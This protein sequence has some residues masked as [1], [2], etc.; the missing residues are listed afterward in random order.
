MGRTRIYAVVVACLALVFGVVGAGIAWAP[1][2]IPPTLNDE[3]RT[4]PLDGSIRSVVVRTDLGEI[5][6]GSGSKHLIRVRETWNYSR[7]TVTHT[8]KNGVLTVQGECPNDPTSWNRCSTD[9]TVVVPSAVTVDAFSNFGDITTKALR[10]N[11][12]LASDF[13]ELRALGVSAAT[14]TADTDY[15][16]VVLDLV[17]APTKASAI[18][19]F[20]DISVKVPAGT[21][22]VDAKTDFGD[23]SVKG[24]D[25]DKDA[26]RR[27]TGHSDYGDVAVARR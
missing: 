27:I 12:K 18:S 26:P 23:V 17:S 20:G 5:I 22:A 15:G 14:M 10:G 2:E 6:V 11:E 13:G 9:L 4:I 1:I 7:P 24:I 19:N 21:Y 8:L 25:T 16:E 3:T